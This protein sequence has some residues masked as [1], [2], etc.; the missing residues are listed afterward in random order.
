[1][2]SDL[3]CT[4]RFV[5]LQLPT[6]SHLPPLESRKGEAAVTRL[7][8]SPDFQE[9]SSGC[10][11]VLLGVPLRLATAAA[12]PSFPCLRRV[13]L[14]VSRLDDSSIQAAA[15]LMPTCYP[16]TLHT[17]ELPHYVLGL[18]TAR[19][20]PSFL[21][22][23]VQRS[24]QDLVLSNSTLGACPE[25][26]ATAART[27]TILLDDLSAAR[28]ARSLTVTARWLVVFS[29]IATTTSVSGPVHSATAW[30]AGWP[31]W[32][33]HSPPQACTACTWCARKFPCTAATLA[34]WHS[35]GTRVACMTEQKRWR[36]GFVATRRC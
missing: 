19:Q 20:L 33:L 23:L 17:L 16:A 28:G 7:L 35:W 8:T 34:C 25:Q 15:A 13:R 30:T 32:P 9:R 11:E 14:G 27:A 4:L 6:L 2:E 31:S 26:E 21:Q 3:L 18:V 29:P 10:L 36:W 5:E 12:L 24:E 22:R 1:M